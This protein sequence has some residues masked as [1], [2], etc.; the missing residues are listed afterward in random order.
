MWGWL[1]IFYSATR[2]YLGQTLYHPQHVGQGRVGGGS[3]G[4]ISKAGGGDAVGQ[5]KGWWRT[6]VNSWL[7]GVE[8][9]T[10]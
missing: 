1:G 5:T 7:G 6:W 10:V 2:M 8:A 4:T 3:G 9:A